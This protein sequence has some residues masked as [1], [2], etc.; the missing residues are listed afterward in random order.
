MSQLKVGGIFLKIFT[1]N[2]YHIAFLCL[3]SILALLS[4]FSNVL[5][6]LI[7]I[8]TLVIHFPTL[9]FALLVVFK[10]SSEKLYLTLTFY[11]FLVGSSDIFGQV[12][13]KRDSIL[14]RPIENFE[15]FILSITI[16]V[17]MSTCN[18]LYFPHVHKIIMHHFENIN[19]QIFWDRASL[20]C[21]V[22]IAV[23]VFSVILCTFPKNAFDLFSPFILI[24]AEKLLLNV[25]QCLTY[26]LG[27]LIYFVLII[28]CS[29]D[30][31]K[32]HLDVVSIFILLIKVDYS[33]I[34]LDKNLKLL[35][36]A[37]K[38]YYRLLNVQ[39]ND[40]DQYL[41]RYRLGTLYLRMSELERILCMQYFT[42]KAKF[43]FERVLNSDIWRNW[44]DHDKLDLSYSI[45]CLNLRTD[46]Q[47]AVDSLLKVW[48]ALKP[49]VLEYKLVDPSNYTQ[50]LSLKQL[51]KLEK[52][53]AM[54]SIHFDKLVGMENSLTPFI[55]LLQPLLTHMISNSINLNAG[56]AHNI[57]EFPISSI[58]IMAGVCL[59]NN[60]L[61]EALVLY[62]RVVVWNKEH[63]GIFNEATMQ[64]ENNVARVS[65]KLNRDISYSS[66][67][68]YGHIFRCCLF[69][70]L[71]CLFILVF[72]LKTHLWKQHCLNG[73][74]LDSKIIRFVSETLTGNVLNGDVYTKFYFPRIFIGVFTNMTAMEWRLESNA[75]TEIIS[76]S[77]PNNDIGKFWTSSVLS[78]K[79][80]FETYIET[81]FKT[82]Y[83]F[84][85]IV[86][87][88]AA[89]KY[90]IKELTSCP[91]TLASYSSAN[92]NALKTIKEAMFES[93]KLYDYTNF[94]QSYKY[95]FINGVCSYDEWRDHLFLEIALLYV[96][97]IWQKGYQTVAETDKLVQLY[98]ALEDMGTVRDK[99]NVLKR[100]KEEM[101]IDSESLSVL[102]RAEKN[103]R[104]LLSGF[105]VDCTERF[106]KGYKIL[107][108]AKSLTQ[109][110]AMREIKDEAFNAKENIVKFEFIALT[111]L[112]IHKT[113]YDVLPQ[114][115]SL[116]QLY[117]SGGDSGD[118]RYMRNSKL[119]DLLSK[120][121]FRILVALII[122]NLNCF[123]H[124]LNSLLERKAG[125]NFSSWDYIYFFIQY[126]IFI[127]A[128]VS[129]LS[130]FFFKCLIFNF[131][132]WTFTVAIA[133]LATVLHCFAKINHHPYE[134]IFGFIWFVFNER[135]KTDLIKIEREI[136]RTTNQTCKIPFDLLLHG[137][138]TENRIVG[139]RLLLLKRF[140]NIC[141]SL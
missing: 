114:A 115:E 93:R 26:L 111:E 98:T 97:S 112:H 141:L 139:K 37:E 46:Y 109:L 38:L 104:T 128:L 52:T 61:S 82:K 44:P 55:T 59:K 35:V 108:K 132:I 79:C 101:G 64:A 40:S 48:D 120:L 125:S 51:L 12:E 102:E 54:I 2:F 56:N 85:K 87:G 121:L 116:A 1:E 11:G 10:S 17:L 96:D 126:S 75:P 130:I 34:R 91:S 134:V 103:L 118:E 41:S 89:E 22:F 30:W 65:R 16:T 76:K 80:P 49:F 135:S 63:L 66:H 6:I 69:F 7:S 99:L 20:F 133:S 27:F 122:Y 29:T 57:E 140:V 58:E 50:S 81:S 106:A 62:E 78:S 68:S 119:T 129:C 39:N 92:Y 88:D 136:R 60:A 72:G 36:A 70:C 31:S 107:H 5:F 19:L 42:L 15:T 18:Y 94:R 77:F 117:L 3:F 45:L 24:C 105:F 123:I 43:N 53:V 28:W 23:F 67:Q 25:F 74:D 90:V 14:Y 32:L 113:E 83:D 137:L 95:L 33:I 47:E 8:G 86:L 84:Y 13:V 138:C 9:C 21:F 71:L 4:L 73:F 100:T 131:S 110:Y 127:D 124:S